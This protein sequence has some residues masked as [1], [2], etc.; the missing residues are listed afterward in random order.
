MHILSIVFSTLFIFSCKTHSS[1]NLE[2][3]LDSTYTA[4]HTAKMTYVRLCNAPTDCIR[5]SKLVMG[6]DHLA[7]ADWVYEGQPEIN[8]EKLYKILDEAAKLGINFF[9]T[10]SIYVGGIENRLG[11]W[12]ESRKEMIKSDSFYYDPDANPDRKLYV[13]S[14]GGFPFDLFYRKSLPAGNHSGT[15]LSTLRSKN[16]LASQNPDGSAE[17][18]NVPP[19][20]YASRL[21]GSKADITESLTAELKHPLNNLAPNGIAIY[22]MHRDDGDYLDFNEVPRQKTPVETIMEAI[23]SDAFSGRFWGYGWS[24]WRTPR[25]D[26]SINIASQKPSLKRP[27]IN[28]PYFSLFEMTDRTIHAGGVQVTHTE[29]MDPSFQKGIYI[30]PY[31]PLGGFSILDKPEPKW[32]NGKASAKK[33]FENGD[34]YW[35]NVYPSIFTE[36]NK[37]RFERAKAFTKTLNERTGKS[38]TVDQVLNAY[39]LAHPRTDL[40]AVGPITTAQLK[41]TVGSLK[42]A[43]MLTA[44][45]LEMLY[46]DK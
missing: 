6:T 37:E 27:L 42:V 17:L 26:E 35:K 41:R 19:G 23:N 39:A 40:L 38:Y 8:D 7:Q 15:F 2:S 46:G 30:M 10:S 32:E 12:I 1:Q 29:M 18:K 24:N 25:I 22:L 28:S 20:T 45:D 5:V 44:S 21:Y 3:N 11:N 4:N 16:I 34:P 36:A 33:K 43:K 9:D 14:K 31:S 13:I